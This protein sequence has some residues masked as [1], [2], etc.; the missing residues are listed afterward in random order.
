MDGEYHPLSN[1]GIESNVLFFGQENCSPNYFFKGNNVREN[2]VIHYIQKGKGIFS[3]AN[4]HVVELKAGD[5]FILPKDVPCFYQADGQDPWSY[6][7]IGLSGTRITSIFK[8]SLLNEKN[9]LRQVQK[10]NFKDYLFQLYDAT[11][12]PASLS[13]DLLIESLLYHTFYYLLTEYPNPHSK[14]TDSAKNDLNL[15]TAYLENNFSDT[16]CNIT[17]LCHKLNISRSYLYSLFKK[18]IALSPQQFLIKLRM[19]KAQQL[20]QNSDNSIKTIAA[21]VGYNDE[22]TFSKAFKKYNGLSPKNYR[23]IN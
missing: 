8:N 3:S 14:N 16:N 18:E 23:L 1:Q 9:Y 7:W 5:V 11:H 17:V 20:L 12:L 2:Y 15:A 13:N 10:S 21:E 4:H 6:F 22:F 19:E